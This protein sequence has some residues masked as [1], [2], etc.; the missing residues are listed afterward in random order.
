MKYLYDITFL[1]LLSWLLLLSESC[2]TKKRFINSSIVTANTD[3]NTIAS[4]RAAKEISS[5]QIQIRDTS[6]TVPHRYI[7]GLVKLSDLKPLYRADG[8]AVPQSFEVKSKGLT[9]KLTVNPDSSI[10]HSAE[11]DSMVLVIKNLVSRLETAEKYYYNKFDSTS[12]QSSVTE[13]S[14]YEF[15]KKSGSFLLSKW[16]WIVGIIVLIF[17]ESIIKFFKRKI[18]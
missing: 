6:I 4:V 17:L 8:V 7:S 18:S 15:F 16:L 11:S 12:S 5:Q 3:K 9:S 13:I 2:A 10:E 14:Y 1:L